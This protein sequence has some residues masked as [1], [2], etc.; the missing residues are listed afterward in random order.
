[1]Y[2]HAIEFFEKAQSDELLFSRRSY[3]MAMWGAAMSTKW[4]LWQASDCVKGKQYLEKIPEDIK[5]LSELEK[6]LIET[7]FALYPRDKECKDDTEYQREKRFTNAMEKV[8]LNFP[9]EI[10]SKL[11]YGLSKA[12]TLSHGECSEGA[13]GRKD[14]KK[15]LETI[16]LLL[17]DIVEKHPTHPGVIHYIIHLFDTPDVFIEGNK[18]FI[19]D[20]IAPED[21]KDHEALPAINAAYD[22][23]N[24]GASSCHGLHM[25]AH[26]FMR[27][28]SWKMSLKSNMMSIKVRFEVWIFLDYGKFK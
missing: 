2:D 18:Q 5:W 8:M 27:L 22:Y 24:I 14:C 13:L 3:P 21:Q 9:A 11:F 28:G 20:M 26:I 25:S 23:L 6:E 15:D 7:A 19:H 10:E 12:A 17:Q 4:M 1:M 16:R